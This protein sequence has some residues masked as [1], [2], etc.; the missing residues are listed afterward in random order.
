MGGG[1]RQDERGG[2]RR[3]A[4]ASAWVGRMGLVSGAYVDSLLESYEDRRRV[5]LQLD[6]S[7]PQGAGLVSR[8]L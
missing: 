2:G 4:E 7:E 8:P 1:V 5:A 6:D 3:P